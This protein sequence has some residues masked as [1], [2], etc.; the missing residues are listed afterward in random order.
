ML[1]RFLRRDY[2][3]SFPVCAVLVVLFSLFWHGCT[4]YD[5][6]FMYRHGADLLAGNWD[7]SSDF[8]SMHG[9]LP[10][11][12]QKWAMCLV[13]YWIYDTFGM[14]GINVAGAACFT[15]TGLLAFFV[16]EDLYP[17][18]EYRNV[19]QPVVLMALLCNDF[20]FSFRP[21]VIAGWAL[22]L[23]LWA[24]ERHAAGRIR[25]GPFLLA[26]A[27]ASAVTMWFHGTMW[28]LCFIPLLP[29]LFEFRFLG[30]LPFGLS[31][32]P[33]RKLPLLLAVPAIVL[34]GVLNPYGIGQ[35][36]YLLLTMSSLDSS[37]FWYMSEIKPFAYVLEYVDGIHV[38]VWLVWMLFSGILL[39]R[40]RRVRGIFFW[41]GSALMMAVAMRLTFQ[42]LLFTWFAASR[43]LT[44][45]RVDRDGAPA[46]GLESWAVLA[47]AVACLAGQFLA[48]QFRY[49]PDGTPVFGAWRSTDMLFEE[50]ARISDA[51]VLDSG[52]PDPTFLSIDTNLAAYVESRGP[53][54]F[55]DTRC[56]LYAEPDGNGVSVL[57]SLSFLKE[58]DDPDGAAPILDRVSA[59]LD[60][61]DVQYVVVYSFYRNDFSDALVSRCDVVYDDGVYAIYSPS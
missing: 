29:Y 39:L 43:D 10:F 13:T 22:L 15:V 42:A 4:N 21:H 23:E 36:R 55:I 17:G 20:L 35:I 1:M 49:G 8:L 53:R 33:V 28:Y 7:R 57:D 45:R 54:A 47:V 60:Y 61:Y 19:L 44:L 16:C 31:A 58:P 26:M 6:F 3:H 18:G 24:L 59:L 38:C 5:V 9:W 46:A 32:E 11:M 56:E 34:A 51:M 41:I 2:R 27:A 48:M 52:K 14:M 30:R 25:T 50:Y 37:K 40:S 12:H